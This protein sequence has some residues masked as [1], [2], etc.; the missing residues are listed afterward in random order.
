MPVISVL[1][2]HETGGSPWVWD[3]LDCIVSSWPVS[4]G[5]EGQLSE[6]HFNK[7]Q[8]KH[9]ERLTAVTNKITTVAGK[10]AHTFHPSH[11]RGRSKQISEFQDSLAYKVS[12][13][14][15]RTV[16]QRNLVSKKMKTNG[17]TNYNNVNCVIKLHG[18]LCLKIP[19]CHTLLRPVIMLDICRST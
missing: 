13:R 9:R 17:K 7:S 19:N 1:N 18:S 11:S 12:S 2:G 10:V 14:T 3:Q 8:I 16:T 6:N 15:A 4:Q 5:Y